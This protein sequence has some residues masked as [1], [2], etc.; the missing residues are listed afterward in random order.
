MSRLA[1]GTLVLVTDNDASLWSNSGLERLTVIK[2]GSIGV[3]IDEHELYP[4]VSFSDNTGKIYIMYLGVVDVVAPCIP[5]FD[6]F[7]SKQ[8]NTFSIAQ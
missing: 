3:I 5:S 1:S 4:T 2:R 8:F 6:A 7:T